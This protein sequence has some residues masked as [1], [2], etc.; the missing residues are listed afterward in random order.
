[1]RDGHTP[2]A[3]TRATVACVSTCVHL[4]SPPPPPTP[5]GPPPP[6][7]SF[8]SSVASSLLL[9]SI[10]TTW[11]QAT[12]RRATV[13]SRLPT[14]LR[15]GRRCRSSGLLSNRRP[16]PHQ[17]PHQPTR[18][19]ARAHTNTLAAHRHGGQDLGTQA[20]RVSQRMCLNVNAARKGAC[21]LACS[22]LG[23]ALHAIRVP[24]HHALVSCSMVAS[25]VCVVMWC[26]TDHPVLGLG[27]RLNRPF[28]GP[29]SKQV[30]V[31]STGVGQIFFAPLGGRV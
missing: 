26:C 29:S 14:A 27:F 10:G 8:F 28:L 1:M 3:P 20:L 24:L 31:N 9:A 23:A 30:G 16:H 5:G 22:K 17:H 15:A 2:P 4:V 25:A 19:N 13:G 11:A 6:L 12:P 7:H 18:A 21:M